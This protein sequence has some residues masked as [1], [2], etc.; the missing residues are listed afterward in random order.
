MKNFLSHPLFRF[1]I[2]GGLLFFVL[3]QVNL[4]E[5][6]TKL[7]TAHP[8]GILIG[9]GG[10]LVMAWLAGWRWAL[11]LVPEKIGRR[12]HWLFFRATMLGLFYNLFMPSSVGGDI[13]KWT[14]LEPLNL[15][16]KKVIL[17][18]LI[19]RVLGMMGMI[20]L[21]FGGL[22]V[23]HFS[24][25][26]AVPVILWQVMSLAFGVVVSFLILISTDWH[27]RQIPFLNR[28]TWVAE[29]EVHLEKHRRSFWLA[30]L[31]SI[32][33]QFIGVIVIFS[34]GKAVGFK[35]ALL[36]FLIIEPILGVVMGLP[37][38]FAGF[39]ATEVGFVYFF[40]LLGESQTTVLALTSLLAA[41]RFAVGGLGWLIGLIGAKV[42]IKKFD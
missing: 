6:V 3:R 12:E 7:A 20:I 16:K 41:M 18:M 8:A 32:M 29:I 21:G 19:D 34:L 30:F 25:L 24:H 26:M 10:S 11:V 36:Q 37:L 31:I 33:V 28:W 5:L 35:L 40:G 1:V 15:P 2:A 14:A 22:L 38:N 9:L 17:T 27:W 4:A 39:G 42:Q 13:L 23:A